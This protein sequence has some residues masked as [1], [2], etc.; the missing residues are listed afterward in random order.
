MGSAGN[1]AM[2][3]LL[4][5]GS[6]LASAEVADTFAKR[7]RGLIGVRT[8]EGAMVLPH[9]R[10]VHTFGVRF[11]LDVAFCDRDMRV[12]AMVTMRPL[13]LGRPRR[14]GRTVI[15]ASA[16]AFGRWGLAVGDQLE[17]RQ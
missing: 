2:S 6:V 7:A 12:V 15:E 13:R 10:A 3:W 16:G 11:P 17:L 9:T 4:R 14:G 1:R 5:D 8:Y